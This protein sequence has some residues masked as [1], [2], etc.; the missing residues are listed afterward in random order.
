VVGV[1]CGR[2]WA[3]SRM[4]EGVQPIKLIR[5]KPKTQLTYLMANL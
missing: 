2:K 4:L 1:V 5:L 3:C